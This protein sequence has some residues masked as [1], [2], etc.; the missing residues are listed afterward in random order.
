MMLPVCRMPGSFSQA[1]RELFNFGIGLPVLHHIGSVLDE[2][3]A[4][5]VVSP[6]H[7][8]PVLVYELSCPTASLPISLVM[9]HVAITCLICPQVPP[10]YLSVED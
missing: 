4:G 1:L 9:S 6:G 8:P 3:N 10:V 2:S 5:S 7:H